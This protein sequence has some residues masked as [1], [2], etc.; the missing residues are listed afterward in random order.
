[1]VYFFPFLFQKHEEEL[2]QVT[3][4]QSRCID[5]REAV[6]EHRVSFILPGGEKGEWTFIH[7]YPGSIPERRSMGYELKAGN[8]AR[9]R[10][11]RHRKKRHII[12]VDK[13]IE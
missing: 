5:P 10:F 3:M 4:V 1:M 9:F 11:R 13:F 12:K 6:D 7:G 2:G 8:W